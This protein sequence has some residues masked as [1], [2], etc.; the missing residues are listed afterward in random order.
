MIQ[1]GGTIHLCHGESITIHN[2]PSG[3]KYM[4]SESDNE[5]YTVVMSGETGMIEAG[6]TSVAAFE[7]HKDTAASQDKPK[8]GD[9]AYPMLCLTFM[10]LSLSGFCLIYFVR[11][12]RKIKKQNDKF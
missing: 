4:V 10:L 11:R 7:N 5:G 1:S 6:K 12:Q 8:T 9:T 3:T 2:L